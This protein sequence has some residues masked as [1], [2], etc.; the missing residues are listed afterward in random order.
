MSTLLLVIVILLLIGAFPAGPVV[1][2]YPNSGANLVWII[3]VVLL[4][5][6]L[7]GRVPA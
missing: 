5:L 3:L 1:R 6:M 2:S 4:V 7:V